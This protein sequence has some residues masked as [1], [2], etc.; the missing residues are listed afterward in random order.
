MAQE[1]NAILGGGNEE[2]NTPEPA[3]PP[4]DDGPLR[5]MKFGDSN[6][7]FDRESGAFK[8]LASLMMNGDRIMKAAN[9]HI[10]QP[11]Q[12]RNAPPQQQRLPPGHVVMGPGYHPPPGMVAI[13]IDQL[14]PGLPDIPPPISESAQTSNGAWSAPITVEGDGIR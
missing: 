14:P 2:T 4:E 12:Q 13:P 3:T 9:E 1:A 11:L 7:A 10:I 5:V 6:L 8:V